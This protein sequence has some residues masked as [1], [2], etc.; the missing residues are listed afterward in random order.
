MEYLFC[1]LKCKRGWHR[2]EWDAVHGNIRTHCNDS[3]D[4]CCRL[5]SI[6]PFV[7]Q[8]FAVKWLKPLKWIAARQ[9]M[10][11]CASTPPSRV[12]PFSR[13]ALLT[14]L[15][16]T[17]DDRGPSVFSGAPMK[18]WF[19]WGRGK[20]N[21]SNA[22]RI[23]RRQVDTAC[24]IG[25]TRTALWYQEAYIYT[26]WTMTLRCHGRWWDLYSRSEGLEA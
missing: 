26:T 3:G 8:K 15:D 22:I 5:S 24:G 11:H 16:I 23:K 19:K 18:S 14:T 17:S 25:G 12:E 4:S 9:F 13:E 21:G 6:P 10:T 20:S 1:Y 7:S 2:R